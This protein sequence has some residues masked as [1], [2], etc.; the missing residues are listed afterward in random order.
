MN[1]HIER[2]IYTIA[3][4]TGAMSLFFKMNTILSILLIL[5]S[6][7]Y[8]F[9]GWLLLNPEH[10]KKFDFLYLIVGYFFSSSFLALLFKNRD[11][12]LLD[13]FIYGSIAMLLLSLILIL[14]IDRARKKPLVENTVKILLLLGIVVAAI[15]V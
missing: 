5:F 7:L 3:I 14:G 12:P 8:L 1:K 6:I 4:A 10:S 2:I 11:Y 15:F 13:M 9:I